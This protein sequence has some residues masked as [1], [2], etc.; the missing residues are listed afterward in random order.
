MKKFLT[1]TMMLLI[2][3]VV[4]ITAKKPKPVINSILR[5][6]SMTPQSEKAKCIKFTCD[7]AS[8]WNTS[9]IYNFECENCTDERVYIEWENARFTKSR[10]IF[11]DDRRI[12]MDN[13]KVD[14]AISAHNSSIS[15]DITGETYIGS[16]Y[17]LA[18]YTP[19]DLKKNLDNKDSTFFT[20]PVRFADNTVVEYELEFSV[21]YEMPI[22]NK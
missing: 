15:R 8:D 22:V 1:L 17:I 16:D 21:W 10:I 11:S 3:S 4:T 20:I 9:F 12:T 7:K 19:K 14:E 2:L 13:P 18:I 6:I 5:V